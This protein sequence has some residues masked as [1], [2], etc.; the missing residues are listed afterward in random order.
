MNRLN[1]FWVIDNIHIFLE[2]YNAETI[3]Q[4]QNIY[5]LTATVCFIQAIMLLLK[6]FAQVS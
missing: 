3:N 6:R 1:T 5:I 2:K 4:L